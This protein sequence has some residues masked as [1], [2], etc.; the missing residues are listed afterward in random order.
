M[1]RS[2]TTR[3][4]EHVTARAM[5]G[6]GPRPHEAPRPAPREAPPWTGRPCWGLL[7]PLAGRGDARTSP[8]GGASRPGEVSRPRRGIEAPLAK[9]LA[10]GPRRGVYHPATDLAGRCTDTARAARDAAA[11]QPPPG[12][13]GLLGQPRPRPGGADLGALLSGGPSS[14]ALLRGGTSPC[15]DAAFPPARAGRGGAG[16]RRAR[17]PGARLYSIMT[18]NKLNEHARQRSCIAE[19]GAGRRGAP[20]ETSRRGLDA[21]CVCVCVRARARVRVYVRACVCM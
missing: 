2:A 21:V 4:A 3:A 15:G 9:L 8:L 14:Q 1:R 19:P 10:K 7:L 11:D 13:P 17:R 20:R 16:R 6:N 5:C 12:G 18:I